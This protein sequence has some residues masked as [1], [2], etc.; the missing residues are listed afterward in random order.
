MLSMLQFA[1]LSESRLRPEDVFTYMAFT[2]GFVFLVWLVDNR[3]RPLGT[4]FVLWGILVVVLSCGY[5]LIGDPTAMIITPGLAKIGFLLVLGG[6]AWSFLP[7]CPSL[8]ATKEVE[9]V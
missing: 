6:I 4:T 3:K 9:H 8:P 2:L 1:V 5:G 7:P